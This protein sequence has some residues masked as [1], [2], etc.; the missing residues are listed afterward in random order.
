M[1]TLLTAAVIAPFLIATVLCL[2]IEPVLVSVERKFSKP[3]NEKWNV[4]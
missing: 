2:A 3:K 4:Q 1:R